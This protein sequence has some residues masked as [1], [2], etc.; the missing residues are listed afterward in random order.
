MFGTMRAMPIRLL[1]HAVVSAA[2][3]SAAVPAGGPAVVRGSDQNYIPAGSSYSHYNGMWARHFD[4]S[5]RETDDPRRAGGAG[6]RYWSRATFDPARFPSATRI[7]WIVPAIESWRR[8]GNPGVYGY[9]ATSYGNYDSGQP[10]HRVAPVQVARLGRF[11]SSV[12]W[13]LTGG[14]PGD[15]TVLQEFY[16]TRTPGDAAAKALEIGLL[17]HP[18]DTARDFHRS[19]KQL[20]TWTDDAGIEWAIARQG[21][22]V[23]LMRAD[24]KD[25]VAGTIDWR[26]LLARVRRLGQVSGTE[27]INGIAVGVEPIRGNGSFRL[28]EW[29]VALR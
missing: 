11:V 26:S 16:L 4:P 7:D 1:S 3:A 21:N 28:D 23:M 9:L 24:G 18:G 15:V 25:L 14:R 22:Y 2:A 13:T 6:S 12:R 10:D 17:L 29:T 8:R 20:G 19:G 27:W 5:L